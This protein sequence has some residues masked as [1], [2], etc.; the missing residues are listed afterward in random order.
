MENNQSF[1]YKL[2]LSYRGTQYRGWQFQTTETETVQNYV[3]QVVASIA[4][5]QK[6]QVIGAS[7][8]DSGVHASGQVLKVTLP[9]EVSPDKLTRGMNSKLPIDIRVVS[10]ELIN[11][12]FN[13]SRD[14]KYK[15][16]HYYFTLD[17]NENAILTETVTSLTEKPNI[18]L[19][20]KACE[21]LIGEHN[22]NSFCSPGPL[23]PSTHRTI[24]K[25]SIE[26]TQLLTYQNDVYYLKI[27][28]TGFLKYMIRYLM[29]AI[30]DIGLNKLSIEDF[31]QSLKSGQQI[32]CRTKARPCGLH[33]IHIEY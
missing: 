13:V 18:Q 22:F 25:C 9:R 11:E 19:M 3:Q 32:G 1:T 5:H 6:Y 16:Y 12:K 17:Q 28:G 23:P 26:K 2:I 20:Q 33:L 14:S 21:L 7:R 29:G 31:N 10:S 4:R 15:E 8:T 24:L 27:Q 30:W